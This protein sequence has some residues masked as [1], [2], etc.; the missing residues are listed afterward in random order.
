MT[1]DGECSGQAAPRGRSVV[2]LVAVVVI[3]EGDSVLLRKSGVLVVFGTMRLIVTAEPQIERTGTGLLEF[4][5]FFEAA[6][7]TLLHGRLPN[8]EN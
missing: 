4:P 1:P 2:G 5:R 3:V 6:V 8:L 7:T